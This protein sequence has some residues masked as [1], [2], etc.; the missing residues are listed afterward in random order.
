MRRHACPI[1][2]LGF[3]AV[4]VA[5]GEE[6]VRL[7]G[8]SD[9]TARRLDDVARLEKEAR[10]NPTRERW[11][12][13]LDELQ[14]ILSTSGN[15]LVS[16]GDGL[17]VPARW[18]CHARVARL[19]ADVLETYRN[20]LES[21][22]TKL[23]EK[24]RNDRDTRPLL[25]LVEEMFCT[26]SAEAGLDLLGDLAFERGELTEAERWWRLVSPLSGAEKPDDERVTVPAYPDPKLAPARLQAKQ[27]LARWFQYGQPGILAGGG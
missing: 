17:L 7:P 1:I 8:E 12:E 20:R 18:R 19:P 14:S 11:N 26:R 10:A 5:I 23:L 15:D 3:L 9:R 16:A 24:G 13:V 21:Q 4:G 25:R 2:C 22:A 6:P 27:L